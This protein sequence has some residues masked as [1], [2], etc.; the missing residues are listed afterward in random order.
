MFGIKR[1]L[2]D[3][4]FSDL[5]REKADW[6]CENCKGDYHEERRLLHLSHF[7]SRRNR[8]VRFD[9]ENA[10]ALCFGCHRKFT[11]NPAIHHEFFRKRLGESRLE[12]LGFRARTPQKIDEKSLVIAFKLELQKLKENRKVFQ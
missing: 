12:A 10:A 8:S 3:K 6:T 9:S 5:I 7:W 2:A 11:E 4:Y 1:S